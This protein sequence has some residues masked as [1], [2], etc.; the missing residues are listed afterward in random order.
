MLPDFPK[1][2]QTAQ[3]KIFRWIQAQ[4][5]VLAPFLGDTKRYV[6]HEG[7][8]NKLIRADQSVAE[9]TMIPFSSTLSLQR[10]EMKRLDFEALHAKL[11]ALAKELT[12]N[13][14]RT[15]FQAV[16]EAAESVGNTVDARGT[17]TQEA[18]LDIFRKVQLSFEPDTEEISPGFQFVMHPETA[19][20]I[21]P[22]VNDWEKDPEFN[23][24]YEQIIDEQRTAWRVRESRRTLAD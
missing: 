2:K 18:F 3:A 1:V 6:L 12:A 9:T 10:E 16:G 14:S 23:K 24:R 11:L 17:L 19:A 4:V 8:G 21:A 15:L 20:K 13:Q 5:P 22:L 7:G